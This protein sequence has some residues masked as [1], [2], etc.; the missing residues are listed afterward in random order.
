MPHTYSLYGWLP[1]ELL[2][3]PPHTDSFHRQTLNHT[4]FKMLLGTTMTMIHLCYT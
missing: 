4:C 3:G 1:I 2:G